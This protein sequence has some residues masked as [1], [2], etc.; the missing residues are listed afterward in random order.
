MYS[1]HGLEIQKL[2]FESE[3][4]IFLMRMIYFRGNWGF[5]SKQIDFLKIWVK[6]NF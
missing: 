3:V 2:T 5:E 6:I 4:Q 1:Y